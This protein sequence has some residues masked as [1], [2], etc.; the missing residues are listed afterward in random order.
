MRLRNPVNPVYFEVA[1]VAFARSSRLAAL[2]LLLC[3]AGCAMPVAAP[4]PRPT[5]SNATRVYV[6]EVEELTFTL[7]DS[8]AEL[9][10]LVARPELESE[11][12]VGGV[13]A[14]LE[15]IGRSDRYLRALRPPADL[16]E[17]HAR[18]LAA[19]GQVCNA[20]A[21]IAE[22][23]GLLDEAGRTRVNGLVAQAQEEMGRAKE[24]LYAYLRVRD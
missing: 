8:A 19:S 4:A 1:E 18:L 12:W 21:L 20:A 6:L 17:P 24:S 11:Q 10:R 22:A 14:N 3:L 2:A 5:T 9:E 16:V 15:L 23:G 7:Q 13:A